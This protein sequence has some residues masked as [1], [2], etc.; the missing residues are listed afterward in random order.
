MSN[1]EVDEVQGL[2]GDSDYDSD[3][4]SDSDSELDNDT[5][6]KPSESPTSK[7]L[8][9]SRD[10]DVPAS[11]GTDSVY[12]HT[13][14]TPIASPTVLQALSRLPGD[15]ARL[16]RQC[17]DECSRAGGFRLIF[18][19]ASAPH[20]QQFFLEKRPANRVLAD[21]YAHAGASATGKVTRAATR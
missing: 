14:A 13:A 10:V 11:D 16:V 5:S 9:P 12:R 2:L 8:S 17:L 15:D 4:D 6:G 19:S 7:L 18:P 1:D 3:G 20:Y 21:W